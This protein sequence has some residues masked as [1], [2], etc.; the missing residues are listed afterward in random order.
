MAHLRSQSWG[1]SLIGSVVLAANFLVL[2]F[3]LWKIL[4]DIFLPPNKIHM[5]IFTWLYGFVDGMMLAAAAIVLGHLDSGRLSER[6]LDAFLWITGVLILFL[7]I[8]E[9]SIIT[10]NSKKDYENPFDDSDETY[11]E[12]N[13]AAG[14][15]LL[16]ELRSPI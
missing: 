10:N 16:H 15:E 13:R 5:L 1:S 14:E 4:T 12:P 11:R 8:Y 2:A 7:L 6:A 3:T 9:V